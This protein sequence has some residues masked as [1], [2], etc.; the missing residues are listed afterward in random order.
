MEFL[1][2]LVVLVEV[3]GR[4]EGMI[5][6]IDRTSRCLLMELLF[7]GHLKLMLMGLLQLPHSWVVSSQVLKPLLGLGLYAST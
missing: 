7:F 6:M 1:L 3:K 2:E 4:G 5:I